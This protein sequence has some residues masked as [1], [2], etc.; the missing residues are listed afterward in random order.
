MPVTGDHIAPLGMIQMTPEGRKK[1]RGVHDGR[2]PV[3]IR[4]QL[5]ARMERVDEDPPAAG[6]NPLG[7]VD[8]P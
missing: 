7:E 8:V 5:A 4:R 6:Y 2:S 3:R 1:R